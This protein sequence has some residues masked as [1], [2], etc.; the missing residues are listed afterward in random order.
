MFSIL[1]VLVS[2]YYPTKD[3]LHILICRY[4]FILI[5]LNHVKQDI[6]DKL[7]VPSEYYDYM[8]KKGVKDLPVYLHVTTILSS[9]SQANVHFLLCLYCYANKFKLRCSIK[10]LYYGYSRE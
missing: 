4:Y 9:I 5:Y 10:N 6:P 1:S 2:Q 7:S 3:C 8:F